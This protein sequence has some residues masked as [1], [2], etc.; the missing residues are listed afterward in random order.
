MWRV[1]GGEGAGGGRCAAVDAG[2]G[3]SGFVAGVGEGAADILPRVRAIDIQ[4][5]RH[6]QV[7]GLTGLEYAEQSLNSFPET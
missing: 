7:G 4:G 1:V 2:F 5:V 3:E 6:S